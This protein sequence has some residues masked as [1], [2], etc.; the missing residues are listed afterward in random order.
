MNREELLIE[1]DVT[2]RGV[3]PDDA[4]TGRVRVGPATRSVGRPLVV[5]LWWETTGQGDVDR[6]AEQVI[7]L[8]PPDAAIAGCT[9]PFSC[10]APPGPLSYE[11]R[12]FAV[13]WRIEARLGGA[14]GG[15]GVSSRQVIVLEVDPDTP[16]RSIAV[17]Q[18]HWLAGRTTVSGDA[19]V[20]SRELVSRLLEEEDELDR[21][22][23]PAR[24]GCAIFFLLGLVL[25]PLYLIADLLGAG[26]L[27]D[28]HAGSIYL[29]V[30]CLFVIAALV[31]LARSRR[32]EQDLGVTLQLADRIVRPGEDLVCTLGVYPV[33]PF[34][35]SSA[36][37]R[38]TAEEASTTSGTGG[39]AGDTTR[40]ELFQTTV[41]ASPARTFPADVSEKL[42][43]R[44]PLPPDAAATFESRHHRVQWRAL[45][46]L[47]PV[48]GTLI[49]RKLTFAVYPAG[50]RRAA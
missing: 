35:I 22:A 49:A 13:E 21:R 42:I 10:P 26:D 3:R 6:G 12:T 17:A 20:L 48:R 28:R 37:I 5:A 46:T 15:S 43:V 23:E 4:I 25:F 18:L 24:I 44:V 39:D 1:L 41:A 19:G 29:G 9:F 27:I 31:A 32:S 11:G 36:E 16:V 50:P 30:G 47:T 40:V 14:G 45:V 33:R 8:A 38:V 34:E 7:D 2:G